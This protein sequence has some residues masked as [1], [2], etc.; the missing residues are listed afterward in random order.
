MALINLSPR[1]DVF[2]SNLHE[3]LATGIICMAQFVTV[4]V[5]NQALAL[6]NTVSESF[7]SNSNSDKAWFSAAFALSVSTL[8]LIS[9]KIGDLYG[10]KACFIA[11]YAWISA[12]SIV[13]GASVYVNSTIFFIICRALLGMGFA[14]LLP[15]AIGLLALCY[16]NGSRKELVWGILGAAAPAGA[17]F[18]GIISGALAGSWSW[19]FYILSISSAFFAVAA[20]FLVPN[21][22]AEK[23][24]DTE[25]ARVS[26]PPPSQAMDWYG[27]V[28]G[29]AGLVLI[30][31]AWNQ[32][33][34]MLW[35]EPYVPVLFAVGLLLMGAFFFLELRVVANPLVPLEVINRKI[36]VTLLSVGLG[37][38]S[39]GVWGFY[40]WALCL[41]L[42]EYT[43]LLTGV[44]YIPVCLF[45][46]LAAFTVSYSISRINPSI[47]IFIS[48][49]SFFASS[50][51]LALTPVNQTY[52]ILLFILMIPLSFAMD[53]SFPSSSLILSNYLPRHHQ[54]TAGSL[55]STVTNYA[56]G[57]ALGVAGTAE[58]YTA[59]GDNAYDRMLSGYRGAMW[60]GVGIAGLGVVTSGGATPET[61]E[62]ELP[63]AAHYLRIIGRDSLCDSIVTRADMLTTLIPTMLDLSIS[64][65]GEFSDESII[66]IKYSGALHKREVTFLIGKNGE[67]ISAIRAGCGALIKILPLDDA[68]QIEQGFLHPLLS[69]SVKPQCIRVSGTAHQIS[70]AVSLIEKC[71]FDYRNGVV[72]Y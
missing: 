54:G 53:M 39:F 24:P 27:G 36:G 7:G 28:T 30:M 26:P 13:A 51:L 35:S 19:C 70:V 25:L 9:G 16:K 58:V 64:K 33:P 15:C 71:I 38:G 52:W 44:S 56:M 42:R 1:P 63:G 62:N 49:M 20:Y 47:L 2:R 12:W 55:V 57:L 3:I 22:R 66:I 68:P 50:L 8:I 23:K 5:N 29:V 69:S 32:A 48:N 59:T 21:V 61:D 10:H 14:F 43:P 46:I 41:N 65:L 34:I 67:R 6:M 31:V 45:G 11:G 40:Y 18:G 4:A 17:C 60:T 72:R 37:W